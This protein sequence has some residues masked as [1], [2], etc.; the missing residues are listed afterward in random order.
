MT[1]ELCYRFRLT[2]LHF[3]RFSYLDLFRIFFPIPLRVRSY[4]FRS[5]T[6]LSKQSY[7]TWIVFLLA[8]VQ[9]GNKHLPGLLGLIER[10]PNALHHLRHLT[11]LDFPFKH[12]LGAI[13]RGIQ[14]EIDGHFAM[15]D[16]FQ[17]EMV[18]ADQQ[19]FLG[20]MLATKLITV[21]TSKRLLSLHPLFKPRSWSQVL[22]QAEASAS[23]GEWYTSSKLI[24]MARGL[25]LNASPNLESISTLGETSFPFTRRI[26]KD[27]L[28]LKGLESLKS[29]EIRTGLLIN[30]DHH[31]SAAN[32]LWCLSL[33]NLKQ[34]A[35]ECFWK[36]EDFF[37]LLNHSEGW[38]SGNYRSNVKELS[39]EMFMVEAREDAQELS[40][41]TIHQATRDLLCYTSH[42]TKL[43]MTA[44]LGEG[45]DGMQSTVFSGL[46]ESFRLCQP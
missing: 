3:S 26:V 12:G 10:A 46:K 15:M 25:I 2:N 13:P 18:A 20:S 43:A 9:I 14:K 23:H 33:P 41:Y 39:L 27:A 28:P 32:L 17:P 6:L 29:L 21:E 40:M 35:L 37:F 19:E 44:S 31:I 36:S 1:I 8:T 38:K 7:E 42:L 34:A 4:T 5:L 24:S 45:Y 30:N 22:A 11:F 16:R